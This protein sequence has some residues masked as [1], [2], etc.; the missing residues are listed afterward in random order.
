[1]FVLVDRGVVTALK[2][3][4]TDPAHS[5]CVSATW[6]PLTLTPS[7]AME[8]ANVARAVQVAQ[9]GKQGGCDERRAQVAAVAPE[10][11]EGHAHAEP[12][13]PLALE[14]EVGRV[15]Q[16]VTASID[17]LRHWVMRAGLSLDAPHERRQARPH[18]CR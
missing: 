9:D 6:R 14:A 2:I 10:D 16:G 8:A 17:A 15:L 18:R 12:E 11:D 7:R 1:M 4:N 13:Q 3:D 5:R